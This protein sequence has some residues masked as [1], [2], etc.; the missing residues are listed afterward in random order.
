MEKF[1]SLTDDKH[2]LPARQLR[3]SIHTLVDS[4]HHDTSKHCADLPRSRE[5]SS[6]FGNFCRLVPR[7]DNVHCAGKGAR[8][9]DTQEESDD[10][11][12]RD[13]LDRGCDNLQAFRTL[14]L[15]IIPS[16]SDIHTVRAPQMTTIKGN[17]M[18]GRTFWTIIP[19]GII[20]VTIL[21]GP[22]ASLNR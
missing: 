5:Q 10:A 12:L 3:H 1:R 19:W 6:P 13:G 2:P 9:T 11:K 22:L 15:K 20:P 7:T 17:Q 21:Q 8:L 16:L 4:R 14:F 18:L